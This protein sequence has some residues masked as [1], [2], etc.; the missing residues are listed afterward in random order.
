MPYKSHTPI[1]TTIASGSAELSPSP[2]SP[3]PSV[4]LPIR[5]KENSEHKEYIG[6]DPLLPPRDVPLQDSLPEETQS[7][8]ALTPAIQAP[9]IMP[10]DAKPAPK[11]LLVE[12]NSI[13]MKVLEVIV[14]RLSLPYSLAFDGR[15]AVDLFQASPLT[16]DI[17]W[18]DIMMPVMDGIRATYHVR[19]I[20][21]KVRR[22]EKKAPVRIIA[23]TGMSGKEIEGDA[24]AVGMD[25]FFTKPVKGAVLKRSIEEWIRS[26]GTES[27]EA[28]TAND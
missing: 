27:E 19:T 1:E 13:N 20:E 12:D 4:V 5:S 11:M 22:E 15:Q 17:I 16:Y 2:A 28:P 18:M 8:Q 25:D 7:N 10:P 21:K 24:R 23:L 9:L 14:K 26:T 3:M 6:V